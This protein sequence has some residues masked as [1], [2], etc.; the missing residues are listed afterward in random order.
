MPE[1][2]L[3]SS[4]DFTLHLLSGSGTEFA[5]ALRSSDPATKR[6]LA[7]PAQH[8]PPNAGE[9][10]TLSTSVLSF[11]VSGDAPEFAVYPVDVLLAATTPP[12]PPEN[13]TAA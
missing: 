5:R 11:T 10:D 9:S 13:S 12:S 6:A 1:P 3:L 2:G 7:P 8:A 4:Y